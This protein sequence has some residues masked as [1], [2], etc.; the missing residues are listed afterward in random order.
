MQAEKKLRGA[1]YHLQRMEE[2]YLKNEEYFVYEL[3]AF[4][5]KVR[6]VPDVLLEDYNGKFSL[7]IGLDEKMSAELFRKKAQDLQNP[8]AID[9]IDWWGTKMGQLRSDNI[10]SLLL[11]KRNVSVHRKEVGPDRKEV[12]ITSTARITLSTT[13]R[14][15]DKNGNLTGETKTPETPP[16]PREKTASVK[17]NWFFKDFP[18]ENVLALSRKLFAMIKDFIEEA[19]TR[20]P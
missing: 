17:T 5:V 12:A 3:E 19:K 15:Y 1:E 2:T 14:A 13:V 8:K 7:G 6:S 10:G 4:L 11:G 16:G 20:F 9:F 18:D